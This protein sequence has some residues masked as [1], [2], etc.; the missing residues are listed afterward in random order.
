[1]AISTG[2]TS[3]EQEILNRLPTGASTD[4]TTA[5]PST[6]PKIKDEAPFAQLSST[7]ASAAQSKTKSPTLTV[8]PPQSRGPRGRRV[9]G[10]DKW[11]GKILEV[12]EDTFTA[13]LHL[14]DH[15]GMPITADFEL[16]LLGSDAEH[17]TP[18]DI[19]YLAV[20]TVKAPGQRP[21]RTE[22]LRLRRLGR[23]SPEEVEAI[24]ARADAL[25][26]RLEQLF[27]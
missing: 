12:H 14:I 13:E 7:P 4:I 23:F 20:R 22:S 1:M 6:A 21:T 2:I 10:L 26:D 25:L 15:S 3:S 8:R 17:A 27:D 5:V 9:T 16:S 11:E 18:G 19:F 24:Q